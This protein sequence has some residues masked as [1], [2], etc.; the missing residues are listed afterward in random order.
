VHG[1]SSFCLGL[2][3]PYTAIYLS[4]NPRVGTGGVVV[5]YGLSGAVNLA[6]ALLL[7][8]GLV[9]PPRV[10]LAVAG[11]LFSCVGYLLIPMITGLPMVAAAAIANGA[12][13]GLFLAAIIPIVNSLV[14]DEERRHVF[15]RRYQ[16]L[17]AT[18]ASGSLVAGLLT[19]VLSRNVIP[20]LFVVNAVGYLPLVV[21]LARY[22]K[23]ARAGERAR[24][25]SP[26]GEDVVERL[27][28]GVGG[29]AHDGAER[30]SDRQRMP[31]G[32]LIKASLAIAL[33]QLGVYLFGYSQ[34]EVTMPLVVD[35]LMHLPLG[36]I[37]VLIAVNVMVIV[38]AQNRVTRLLEGR[39]EQFGL[40]AAIALWLLGYLLVGLTALTAV[41]IPLVGLV[42]FAVLFALGEC[43]YSCSFHPWLISRVPEQELTRANALCNSMMGIGLLTGPAVGVLLV[44]SQS[45]PL[46]WL[47]LAALCAP[48]AL[49]TRQ[50]RRRKGVDAEDT[51]PTP[52]LQRPAAATPQHT[53]SPPH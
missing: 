43:A 4:T 14:T 48:V 47:A 5:Y 34:F 28:E 52:P 7:A 9:R 44:S 24:T 49:T 29:G 10:A 40:R 26:A 25:G 31:V 23:E 13:Q 18:L 12:G 42:A 45:A 22:R 41:P 11:N 50:R 6:V 27:D 46:V 20:Y 32:L 15:A 38:L 2:V 17:N 53:K 33:F 3:F 51:L 37:S 21:I 36:W 16:V 30:G 19:S 35:Q 39:S 1:I 8:T